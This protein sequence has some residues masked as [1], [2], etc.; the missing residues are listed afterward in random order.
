MGGVVRPAVRNARYGENTYGIGCFLL[1]NT[2]TEAVQSRR[3]LVTPSSGGPRGEVNYAL[4]GAVFVASAAIQWLRDEMKLIH[5][6]FGIFRLQSERHQRRVCGES[7]YRFQR[8]P[9]WNPYARGAIFGITRG[10]N[11]NHIIRATLVSIV[12]QTRDLNRIDS[13]GLRRTAESAMGGDGGLV[14]NNFLMQ[15]QSDILGTHVELPETRAVTVLGAAY[16]GGSGGRLW[17]DL[18][19]VRSKW[20]SNKNSPVLKIIATKARRKQ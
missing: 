11:T 7:F 8:L 2:G 19:A 14:A 10:V 5:H 13:G 15:F 20:L 12:F 17:S 4:E 18:E 6:R 16:L 1:I 3:R 9:N